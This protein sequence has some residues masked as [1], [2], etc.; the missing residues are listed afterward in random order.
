MRPT[1]GVELGKQL[2]PVVGLGLQLTAAT[3]VSAS[4][5]IFSASNLSLLGKFNL[6]NLLAGYH[7]RPRVFEL[8]AVAGAGWGHHYN[9][10]SLGADT[11][12]FTT[13]Y[14]LNFNFNLGRLR[15]WTLALRP[16]IVYEMENRGA[17]NQA[18][19]NVNCSAVELMAG[20]TYHFKNHNNGRHHFTLLRPYDQGEVDAL[21]AKINDLRTQLNERD[22]ELA[23]Q[24]AD[25][26][27]LQQLL[28][29][30][31]DQK[32][33]VET[34]T[35]TTNTHSLEQTVTFRQGRTVVEP[36]QLPNVE[37]V[38][39]FLRNHPR[40]TVSIRGYASPE[41]SAEINAQLAAARA[42]AVKGILVS[43]YKIDPAR[44][45]AEGQ[46]VG[47]M[48]SEPDWNRVSICTIDEAD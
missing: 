44:I 40:A 18:A 19:Y 24:R 4:H 25:V 45:T 6:S 8:E 3:R 7:G 5:T 36:S 27:E 29:E 34:Q 32:P 39:T 43:K 10:A 30:C 20:V 21:N 46:G 26:R 28:N 1:Y 13:K 12:G 16:A 17:H 42:A 48:F 2:T 22:A 11:N 41:G 14:G 33:V 23:R 38:A 47:D 15:A 9:H 37:R 31:R 35:I